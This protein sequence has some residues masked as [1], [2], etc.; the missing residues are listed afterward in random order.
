MEIR[1]GQE[2]GLAIGQP[3]LGSGSLAL[4]AVPVAAG[5]V[6]DAQMGAGLAAFDMPAQRR[7]SA[8]LDRRHDLQLAEAH[9]AGM[10]RTPSWPVAAE[11]IRH[12]DHWP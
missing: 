11:D 6:A 12:L 2:F 7:R 5:V 4:W 9:M 3:F 8:A 10:G 1:Y